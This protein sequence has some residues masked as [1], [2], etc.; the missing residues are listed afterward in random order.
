MNPKKELPVPAIIGAILL[1]LVILYFAFARPLIGGGG[2]P[3]PESAGAGT[4]V[5]PN[6][7]GD[8]TS[9]SAANAPQ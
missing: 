8:S 1:L 9:N 7:G 6:F 4:P 2:A 5:V 3:T